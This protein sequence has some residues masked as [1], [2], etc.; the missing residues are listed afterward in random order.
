[1]YI[2]IYTHIYP[3]GAAFGVLRELRTHWASEASSLEGT[4]EG[5][6]EAA[7]GGPRPMPQAWEGEL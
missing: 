1:M 5:T 3:F 2:Y 7:I 6:A 4:S